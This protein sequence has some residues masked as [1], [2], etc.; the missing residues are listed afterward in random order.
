MGARCTT[1][2]KRPIEPARLTVRTPPPSELRLDDLTAD[3]L[4]LV[5]GAL[6]P[7]DEL[8]ASLSCRTVHAA[9]ARARVQDGRAGSTTAPRSALSSVRKLE[10]AFSCGLPLSRALCAR[11]A[12]DGKLAQLR[13]LRAHGSQCDESTCR[14]AAG[15]GHLPVLQYLRA[16]GCPWNK[17]TCE[18]ASYGGHLKVLRWARA[19]G[20]PW[21]HHTTE[22]AADGGHLGV[23]QWARANGC[24]WNKRTCEA[25]AEGGHLEVLRWVRANG[26]PWCELTCWRAAW[27]GHIALLKWA[28]AHGCPLGSITVADAR[29][30]R[31]THLEQG[32]NLDLLAE[33]GEHWAGKRPQPEDFEAVIAWLRAS[34]CPEA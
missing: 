33:D 25:A 24:P 2:G 16:H 28:Y 14:A 12:K 11:A 6:E 20:C 10:W 29:N 21:D 27:G 19:R 17:R 34:G 5:A 22:A 9:V 7:D 32:S 23:L 3:A 8:A 31:E 13:W 4:A 26:C 30:M 18:A 1:M 15:G